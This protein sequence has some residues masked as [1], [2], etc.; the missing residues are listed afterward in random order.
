M[1]INISHFYQSNN[2]KIARRDGKKRKGEKHRFICAHL[3]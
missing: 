2:L 1:Y 3:N